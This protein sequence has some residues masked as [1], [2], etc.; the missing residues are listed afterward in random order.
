MLHTDH[1]DIP[2]PIFMPVGTVG[3][4]KAI[5][6]DVLQQRVRA[7]IILGNTYHLYLRPGMSVL[8]K[9][10]GLHGFMNWKRPILTDSGGYQVFSLAGNRTLSEEGATFKSHLDGSKHQ[11]TPENVVDIQ[12]SIGSDIMML[13]DECPPF[14]SQKDYAVQ[15]MH[16]THRW[17][18]RGRNRFL[19]TSPK[20]GHRQ[21]QFGI[22]QG[23]VFPELRAESTRFMN[24]LNFEGNA[25][26]GL[27]VGEP[28]EVMYEMTDLSTDIFDRDKPRY[29]MGVGTPANLLRN[30][31]LGV[32]MF[33]CVMPTRNARN[34]QL[35]TRHGIINLRN[36]KWRDEFRSVDAGFDSPLCTDYSL[37]YL[38][39][40]FK[41]K[42]ILG[43]ML[44]TEHNLRFYLWLMEQIR[45][46][47]QKDE[48]GEW[49][50]KMEKQVAQRL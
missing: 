16:L 32:D 47:I 14:P 38:H 49:Y 40:L 9:A 23:S 20:Y 39:H 37:A 19:G 21:H 3:S 22:A 31:A 25:I 12:R 42:E 1:G 17:A 7:R 41:A 43:L 30:V 5:A 10:G 50:P 48:F 34:G 33:D 2:T 29:L 36:A 27:S 44:A 4:V 13:L 26:G 11:F 45:E 15:S 8:E 35:F 18:Q 24:D 46:H 6:Q 28:T